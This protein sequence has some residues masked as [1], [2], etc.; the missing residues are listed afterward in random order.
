MFAIFWLTQKL[1]QIYGA[2]TF[3]DMQYFLHNLKGAIL[4]RIFYLPLS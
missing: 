3:H 4:M 1:T 2:Q